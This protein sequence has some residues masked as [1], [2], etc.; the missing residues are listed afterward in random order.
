MLAG[1]AEADWG[2]GKTLNQEK[3]G[4]CVVVGAMTRVE[5][6]AKGKK[7]PE[8][9]CVDVG[10]LWLQGHAMGGVWV[11]DEEQTRCK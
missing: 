8:K 4:C 7:T 11:V 2:V 3:M 1:L 5:V 6:V 9:T 10:R